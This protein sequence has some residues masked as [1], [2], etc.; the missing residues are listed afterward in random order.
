[1]N[2]QQRNTLDTFVKAV[3]FVGTKPAILANATPGFAT[4]VQLLMEAVATIDAAAPDRASGKPAKAATQ[5]AVLRQHLRM[6]EL[7]PIRRVAR[8]LERNISGMT[9]LVNVPHRTAS[10]QALLDAAKATARDVAPYQ[11]LFVDK[12]LPTDFLDQLQRAI[13]AV[14]QATVAGQ[15]ARMAATAARG[16]LQ[17]AFRDG[18]DALLLIDMVVRR[19]CDAD[20]AS[21]AAA[22]AV[23]NTIVSPRGRANR[24]ASH[25]VSGTI[26]DVG[27]TATTSNS[28][29]REQAPSGPSCSLEQNDTTRAMQQKD[30]ARQGMLSR[31]AQSSSIRQNASAAPWHS[32]AV[33]AR[34]R[35]C[36]VTT[37]DYVAWDRTAVHSEE[38]AVR[39]TGGG[40]DG[41]CAVAALTARGRVGAVIRDGSS[42]LAGA[43]LQSHRP[44]SVDAAGWFG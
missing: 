39:T 21:G 34:G 42:A 14:E 4:Q 11:E 16:V 13:L 20:P 30:H 25:L 33:I 32:R 19:R 23:W 27:T 9:K 12:G 44:W 38:S 26:A 10:T 31:S 22:L 18:R 15:A 41:R 6:R 37:P 5:R 2:I 29:E 8:V 43:S 17:Q 28:V 7:S 1:M 40:G 24:T 35:Q 36:S 3:T